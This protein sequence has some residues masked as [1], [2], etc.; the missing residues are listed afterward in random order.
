[1]PLHS[2]HGIQRHDS[3]RS[4]QSVTHTPLRAAHSLQRQNSQSAPTLRRQGSSQSLPALQRQ[5]SSESLSGMS[6]PDSEHSVQSVQSVRRSHTPLQNAVSMPIRRQG[7]TASLASSKAGPEAH[8]SGAR[9]PF[10]ENVGRR[11]YSMPR[12]VMHVHAPGTIQ[13]E[14]PCCT[15]ERK[16]P[17]HRVHSMPM[18]S[19][20]AQGPSH[21]LWH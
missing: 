21:G 5:H 4:V 9:R 14:C 15:L 17:R 2:A 10:E 19:S 1:M 7:S 20:M 16:L 3:M 8:T 11:S 6:R 12:R 18:T 13:E